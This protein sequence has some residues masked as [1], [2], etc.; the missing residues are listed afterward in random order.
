MSTSRCPCRETGCT[1]IVKLYLEGRLTDDQA[2]NLHRLPV[3]LREMITPDDGMR[4]RNVVFDEDLEKQVKEYEQ[5]LRERVE[6]GT[7]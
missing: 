7:K 1:R 6:E 2:I 5:A 4:V 3:T